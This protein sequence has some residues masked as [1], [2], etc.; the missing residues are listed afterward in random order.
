LAPK[1]VRVADHYFHDA[2]DLTRR[3]EITIDE[4][5]AVKS[6]RVKCFID[7]RIAYECILKAVIVYFAGEDDKKKSI[8]LAE[9]FGHRVNSLEE[10]AGKYFTGEFEVK[11]YSDALASLPVSLR[12]K[13]DTFDFIDANEEYYY[14][15]IGSDR[16]MNNLCEY[17]KTITAWVDSLLQSHSKI[18]SGSIPIEELLA[19]DYNKYRK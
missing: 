10:E 16:W 18:I 14:K 6:K 9:S 8:K 12:Y 3:Y 15:T 2:C 5:F 1:N 19:V 11:L 17:I 7:L 4:W 13:L